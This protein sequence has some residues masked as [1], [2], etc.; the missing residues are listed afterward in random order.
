MVHASHALAAGLLGR[1]GAR[2]TLVLDDSRQPAGDSRRRLLQEFE[3]AVLQWMDGIAP[4]AN[5]SVASIHAV[6]DSGDPEAGSNRIWEVADEYLRGNQE[7]TILN[8]LRAAKVLPP[9]RGHDDLRRALRQPAWR[10]TDPPRIWAALD[11]TVETSPGSRIVT[12]GSDD[13]RPMWEE[14]RR[15]FERPAIAH[16]MAPR[17]TVGDD[18]V[19]D[20]H[21]LDWSAANG[22]A[23]LIEMLGHQ[24]LAS[25]VEANLLEWFLR[26]ALL[27]RAATGP[28]GDEDLYTLDSLAA[29]VQDD[30][31]LLRELAESV[32]AW[33]FK[34]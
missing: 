22:T 16:L 3:E 10:L 28:Q 4:T 34:P 30:A 14:Y 8:V 20:T 21:E 6:I 9:S 26:I 25:S 17:L 13:E 1:L 15:V 29:A 27:H 23:G 7:T 5:F 33:F 11:R 24:R 12:L 2:V 18:S 31:T 32:G 19:W